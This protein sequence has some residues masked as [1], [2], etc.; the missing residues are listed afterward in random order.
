V[1]TLI[2]S[3]KAQDRAQDSGEEEARATDNTTNT[4]IFWTLS[5]VVGRAKLVNAAAD[6][7][8]GEEDQVI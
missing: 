1:G 2:E 8:A 6:R 3:K 5:R 4:Q 7:P